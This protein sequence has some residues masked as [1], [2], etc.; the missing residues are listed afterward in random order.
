MATFRRGPPNWGKN[1]YFRPIS[2]FGI[3][4]WSNVKCRD[5]LLLRLINILTYLLT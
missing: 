2:V 3:D 5:S 4:D 1:R